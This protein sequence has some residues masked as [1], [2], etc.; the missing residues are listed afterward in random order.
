MEK[1]PDTK[2]YLKHI[3]DAIHVIDEY[4]DSVSEKEF[5]ETKLLQD[6]VIRQLEI[7][8]M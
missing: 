8:A 3:R 4:I 6:G 2:V 5:Y 1:P 7:I